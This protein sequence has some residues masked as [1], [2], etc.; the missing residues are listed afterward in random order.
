MKNITKVNNN[1]STPN[2]NNR[3]RIG[4]YI[5]RYYRKN[6]LSVGV[7]ITELVDKKTKEEY[8]RVHINLDKDHIVNPQSVK[9]FNM[10]R[11][12][13]YSNFHQNKKGHFSIRVDKVGA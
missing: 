4:L 11:S 9:Q 2:N 5:R 13:N 8:Y 7:T 6:G 1:F 12:A 3:K 10:L